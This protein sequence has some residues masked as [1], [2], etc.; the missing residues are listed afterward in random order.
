MGFLWA[1]FDLERRSM[2]DVLCGTYVIVGKPEAAQEKP[3]VQKA[4]PAA[5]PARGVRAASN[6]ARS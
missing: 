4:G 5:S 2:H 6:S 3:V 1:L